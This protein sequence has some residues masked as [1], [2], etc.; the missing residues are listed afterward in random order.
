M[1][2]YFLAAAGMRMQLSAPCYREG[3]GVGNKLQFVCYFECQSLVIRRTAD[4]A[5]YE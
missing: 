1:I 5:T 2:C 4:L 3:Q